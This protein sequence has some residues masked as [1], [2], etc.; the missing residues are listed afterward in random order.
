M[1]CLEM[2][3]AN[4]MPRST[5]SHSSCFITNS[6]LV[7]LGGRKAVVGMMMVVKRMKEK[8]DKEEEE[9]GKT[10][11]SLVGGGAGVKS[12]EREAKANEKV[13][14]AGPRLHKSHFSF[15]FRIIHPLS[16]LKVLLRW[17]HDM[18]TRHFLT[19]EE[20]DTKIEAR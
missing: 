7:L 20:I 6:S 19:R 11:E 15:Y 10:T 9:E 4:E 16:M 3:D 2:R 12:G 13:E 14:T 17:T 5:S 18:M 8:L 1:M